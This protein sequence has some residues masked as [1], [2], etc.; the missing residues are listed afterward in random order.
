MNGIVH[1][2]FFSEKN[3]NL[4]FLN[5]SL[6]KR[7]Y[8]T[9]GYMERPMNTTTATQIRDLL[10]ELIPVLQENIS[11]LQQE[12]AQREPLI[13][14]LLNTEIGRQKG[15]IRRAQTA[16]KELGP[17]QSPQQSSFPIRFPSI[18]DVTV[19]MSDGERI[20]E[21]RVVDTFCKVIEKVGTENVKVLNIIVVRR[22]QLPLVSD[23]KDIEDTQRQS[24]RY[25]IFTRSSTNQKL[26]WLNAIN[27]RLDLGMKIIDNREDAKTSM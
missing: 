9:H 11:R 10:K 4:T 20:E 15:L 19:I 6:N 24:G 17:Q 12:S 21:S 1:R 14:R 26:E 2:A 13:Q 3:W 5:F 8:F 18:G 22:R 7:W 16:L 27:S 25:F 23:Y